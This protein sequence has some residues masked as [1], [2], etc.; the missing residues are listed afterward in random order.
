MNDMEERTDLV[1]DETQAFLEGLLEVM[2]RECDIIK[3][4]NEEGD[5][6]YNLVGRDAG[7]IIGYRGEVLDAIQYLALVATGREE[8]HRVHI[9]AEHYRQKRAQTLTRLADRLARKAAETGRPQSLEPMNPYER[10]VIHTALQDS[11]FATTASEGEGKFRHVV[12]LPKEGVKD[13][14]VSYGNSDFRRTG[15]QRTRSFGYNKRKF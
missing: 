12:I 6:V 15:P 3:E 1:T 2:R 10:R 8:G 4:T 5:T 14:S 7:D 11:R 13:D 9:D